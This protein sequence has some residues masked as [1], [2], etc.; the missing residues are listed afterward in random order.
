MFELFLYQEGT[1]L[2]APRGYPARD[3]VQKEKMSIRETPGLGPMPV[4]VRGTSV[5]R[6]LVG[7]LQSTRQ[8]AGAGARATG[9]WHCGPAGTALVTESTH[10][11][12]QGESL[13]GASFWDNFN[14]TLFS[15]QG[16]EAIS[17]NLPGLAN[18]PT[19]HPQ[20][21]VHSTPLP[22]FTV[23]KSCVEWP[24]S[25]IRQVFA[26]RASGSF[27]RSDRTARTP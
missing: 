6:S 20:R 21:G 8:G 22:V 3:Q 17:H 9:R 2:Q 24:G 11:A 26:E 1:A 23:R 5:L 15:A 13:L 12:L 19:P 7:A 10:L 16:W 4:G 25:P 18:S 27:P 14:L